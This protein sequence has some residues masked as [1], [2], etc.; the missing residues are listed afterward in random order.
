MQ[1][2]SDEISN[3]TKHL[4]IPHQMVISSAVCHFASGRKSP[5]QNLFFSVLLFSTTKTSLLSTLRATAHTGGGN[6]LPIHNQSQMT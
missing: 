6:F 1:K 4:P 2:K 3:L 5:P